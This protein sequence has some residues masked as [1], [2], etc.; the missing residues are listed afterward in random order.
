ML[1][2]PLSHFHTFPDYFTN[3]QL[4]MSS[5]TSVLVQHGM[6]AVSGTL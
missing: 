3:V 5:I 4:G 2:H 1:R 6:E